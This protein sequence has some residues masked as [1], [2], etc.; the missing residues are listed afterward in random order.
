MR[1]AIDQFR[2]AIRSA[3]L[4]PPDMIEP[5][6]SLHRF[7]SN[8]KRGDDTGWYTLYDDGIP[9]G[10]FGDWRA[11][12][13]Q[14]WRADIGRTLNAAEEAA[15]RAKVEVMQRER[16]AAKAREQAEAANKAV[17][18]W[19]A[20]KPAPEDHPYLIRKR[21]KPNGA[22]LHHDALVIPMRAGGEIH[23]LQFIGPDGD[24]RFLTGG[25]VSGC[26]FSIGNPKGA[27]GLCIAEG[28]ATGATIH[29][30]T[31]CPVAVAFNAGNLAAVAKA[32]RERFRELPLILCADDDAATEGN[33]GITKATEAARSV[34]GLLA[35][36]DFGAERQE[37]QTDFNDMAALHGLE[38]VKQAIASASAPARR[39][40]QSD[41]EHATAGDSEGWP[42][43]QPLVAKLIPQAVP[44][45]Q[46]VGAAVRRKAA[47]AS[48]LALGISCAAPE[49]GS[50]QPARH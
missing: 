37:G 29:E 43:P 22:R 21:N 24:K 36:P 11:G 3:V 44:E 40:Y 47:L 45:L 8:G 33:A 28:F 16:E 39:E 31:G 9:V 14:I 10:S 30:A 42:E 20:A 49:S 6:G 46:Q 17:A 25:R 50:I 41:P 12:L 26:Y 7:A 1:D 48:A 15:H 23:S 35:I 32:M 5:D 34:G 19:K 2:D 13:S 27:T 18:I 4:I 38:A